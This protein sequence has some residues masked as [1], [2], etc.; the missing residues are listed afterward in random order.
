MGCEIIG[1]LL[2][3][4]VGWPPTPVFNFIEF[5]FLVLVVWVD[6][7]SKFS[8]TICKQSNEVADLR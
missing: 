5:L 2:P 8:S 6:S 1:D 4:D 7:I 3:L